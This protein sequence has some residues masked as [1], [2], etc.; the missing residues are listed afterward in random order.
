MGIE[1]TT[2]RVDTL[3]PQSV[4]I[5]SLNIIHHNIFL[6]LNCTSIKL[7]LSSSISKLISRKG[8]AKKFCGG[9]QNFF[10]TLIGF[11]LIFRDYFYLRN[12][13]SFK[14][15][16]FL[17]YYFNQLLALSRIAVKAEMTLNHDT[18]FSTFTQIQDI[19]NGTQRRF[20]SNRCKCTETI[21]LYI[22]PSD[23]LTPNHSFYN[24]TALASNFKI[25]I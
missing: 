8:K 22:P 2:C 7:T 13:L 25:I 1:P 15:S 19:R 4:N 17:N 18:P 14:K 12:W 3:V 23:D 9:P 10:E 5:T 6:V 11:V 20:W 16:D 24:S 21:Q